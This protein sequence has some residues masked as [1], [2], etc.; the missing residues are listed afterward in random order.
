MIFGGEHDQYQR[1]Y[2]TRAEAEAG[3]A[4]AVNMVIELELDIRELE[5]IMALSGGWERKE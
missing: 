5:R 3:H 1:R 4:E 2:A